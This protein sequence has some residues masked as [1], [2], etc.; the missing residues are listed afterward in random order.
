LLAA[1]KG[2]NENYDVKGSVHRLEQRRPWNFGL[3]DLLNRESFDVEFSPSG[4]VLLE[5]TYT[6]AGGIYRSSRFLYNE[7][8]R[9]IRTLECNSSGKESTVS[10]FEYAEGK[11][12]C[13]TRDAAGIETGRDVEEYDGNF[14]T[15]IGTYGEN[16]QLKRLKSFEYADGKLSR[17]VSKYYGTDKILF[18]IST[19]RYDSLGRIVEAFGL[20]PDGNPTGDGRYV[21]EYDEEG[22]NHK[23]LSY[24][25]LADAEIP[26]SIRGFTYVCDEHGNW[27]E[28]IGYHRSRSDLAWTKRTTTRTLSY[29]PIGPAK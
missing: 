5:T 1:L 9:L 28:R 22:R 26:I 14:L 20:G 29:Y 4:Q 3:D 18:E 7:S 24:N 17:A 16:G 19:T 8:G 25:D 15:A 23:I 10:E 13:I 12:T 21:Y 27:V 11:R 2:V 6:N